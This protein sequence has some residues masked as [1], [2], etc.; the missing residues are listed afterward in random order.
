MNKNILYSTAMLLASLTLGAW[1]SDSD[2]N[3]DKPAGYSVE[4]VRQAEFTPCFSEV[5]GEKR[6]VADYAATAV[7]PIHESA[8]SNQV[9]KTMSRGGQVLIK[10]GA[11]YYNTAGCAHFRPLFNR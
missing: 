9:R 5:R 11:T 7:L 4:T 8:D 6:F 3:N 1:G 10:N 2:D